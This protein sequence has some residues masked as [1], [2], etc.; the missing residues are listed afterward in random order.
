LGS[1]VITNRLKPICSPTSSLRRPD[2]TFL[3]ERVST[4][5]K[6]RPHNV[7]SKSDRRTD[8]TTAFWSYSRS[9]FWRVYECAGGNRR[10]CV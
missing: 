1:G 5:V 3:P 7:F 8:A 6:R 10:R 4:I 9:I 2:I